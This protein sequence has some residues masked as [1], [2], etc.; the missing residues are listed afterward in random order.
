MA[1]QQR[2]TSNPLSDIPADILRCAHCGEPIVAKWYGNLTLAVAGEIVQTEHDADWFADL[3]EIGDRVKRTLCWK[4][5]GEATGM[6]L[7]WM[8]NEVT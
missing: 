7:D 6:V 3:K 2:S 1:R 4:C 5:L 8:E